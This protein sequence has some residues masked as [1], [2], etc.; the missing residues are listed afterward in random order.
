MKYCTTPGEIAVTNNPEQVTF[1]GVSGG[2]RS[3][4]CRGYSVVGAPM[5]G[6][7]PLFPY[8]V[9]SCDGTLI[10]H[11]QR[12]TTSASNRG[13]PLILNGA[14]TRHEFKEPR[15]FGTINASGEELRTVEVQVQTPNGALDDGAG[16]PLFAS[17][18]LEL[19]FDTMQVTLDPSLIQIRRA[20]FEDTTFTY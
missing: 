3:V 18:V 14:N 16:N 13:F 6:G 8:L 12:Q 20:V 10:T 9:V 2:S 5:G 4:W 1:R 19:L 17:V 7:S 11:P 15:L